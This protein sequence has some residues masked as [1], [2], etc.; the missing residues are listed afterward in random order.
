M[1]SKTIDKQ[2]ER[3]NL[4]FKLARLVPNFTDMNDDEKNNISY[5][6]QRPTNINMGWQI[7]T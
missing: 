4:F 7:H 1:F 6:Q 2:P 5:V 3:E